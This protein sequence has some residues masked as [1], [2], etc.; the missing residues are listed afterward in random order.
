MK[1][2]F[3]LS[4]LSLITSLSGCT[5]ETVVYDHV[6][7]QRPTQTVYV[8]RYNNYRSS[9]SGSSSSSPATIPGHA[10]RMPEPNSP[11]NFRAESG[12]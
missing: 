11:A 7:K 8:H 9:S 3:G 12:N 4:L 5:H 6:Y 2:I 1:T 10:V